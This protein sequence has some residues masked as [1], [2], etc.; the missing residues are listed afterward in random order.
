MVNNSDTNKFQDTFRLNYSYYFDQFGSEKEF[1]ESAQK[2][3]ND[4]YFIIVLGRLNNVDGEQYILLFFNHQYFPVEEVKGHLKDGLCF[5]FRSDQFKGYSMRNR[6]KDY[7]FL[8]YSIQESI[9]LMGNDYRLI[10][11]I[12]ELIA[13]ETKMPSS[14]I[15]S[16][17]LVAYLNLLLQHMQRFYQWSIANR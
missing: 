14:D 2:W 17:I 4:N 9:P 11:N 8:A 6:L 12:F 5:A 7:G 3:I 16:T 10:K 15:H 1:F 13:R